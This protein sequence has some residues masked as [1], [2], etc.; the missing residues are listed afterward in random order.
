MFRC[1]GTCSV[2]D[3]QNLGLQTEKKKAHCAT[4]GGH[5]QVRSKSAQTQVSSPEA[6]LA[7]EPEGMMVV[8]KYY[9]SQ[10]EAVLTRKRKKTTRRTQFCTQYSKCEIFQTSAFQTTCSQ[11][12]YFVI[13]QHINKIKINCQEMKKK[14]NKW[15]IQVQLFIR[16]NKCKI[17]LNKYNL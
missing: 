7:H 13:D 1:T 14:A 15:K 2:W 16:F 17:N 8:C 3:K 5:A 10:A 9:Q 11:R 6:F 4:P 12:R